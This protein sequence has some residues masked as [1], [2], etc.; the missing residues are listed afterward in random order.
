M[1]GVV[2]DMSYNSHASS[3]WR[4]L[5]DSDWEIEGA[6]VP[7][8]RLSTSWT[9]KASGPSRALK[10]TSSNFSTMLPSDLVLPC[11]PKCHVAQREG[12]ILLDFLDII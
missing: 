11:V 6:Q 3:F 5:S 9:G 2:S 4:W 7:A 12:I 8:R 1:I 10:A